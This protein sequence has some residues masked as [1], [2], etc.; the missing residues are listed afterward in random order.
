VVT[1]ACNVAHGGRPEEVE[2]G[3]CNLF[4][5]LEDHLRILDNFRL[6]MLARALFPASLRTTYARAYIVVHPSAKTAVLGIR[7]YVTRVFRNTVLLLHDRAHQQ[8]LVHDEG[9]AVQQ[10][11]QMACEGTRRRGTPRGS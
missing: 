8:R 7:A 4:V 3:N 10:R 6:E 5:E 2:R 11:R 9:R 1:T